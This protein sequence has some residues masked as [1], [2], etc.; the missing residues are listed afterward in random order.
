[1]N[2]APFVPPTAAALLVL[3]MTGAAQAQP[4]ADPAAAFGARE[5]VR[6]V[7]LSPDGG[8]LIYLAPN[9]GRSVSLYAVDLSTGDSRS[10]S[11]SSGEP[12][13]YDWCRFASNE[14]L[15]CGLYGI[16]RINS[17]LAGTVQLI[18]IGSDGS[19]PI[20]IIAP[21]V[22]GS[23]IDWMPGAEN[24]I[25]V[26]RPYWRG[27]GVS[28]ID[29]ETGDDEAVEGPRAIFGM[30]MTDGHG[31]I[32]VAGGVRGRGA[33]GMMGD[34]ASYF[35]R[36]EDEEKWNPLGSYNF[37]TRAG[38]YPL[39]VDRERNV[40]YGID[41]RE[42]RDALFR[43]SL[44]GDL[45]RELVFAHD[46]VDLDGVVRIGRS[47]RV[48]GATFADDRRRYEYFDEQY[49][50]LALSLSRALPD[51]P[52]IYFADAS[53]DENVLLIW[54]GSDSDPGRYYTYDR[55]TRALNEIMLA[56]PQLEQARL[57]SVRAISYSAV[58]GMMI[59]GYLTMPP[60]REEARGLPAIVM[61]HGGP[62]ARDEWGFDWLAQYFAYQGYAV[63]QPNFRGSAGYGEDWFVVNGFQGWQTAIGDVNAGGDW[64]VQ[65]GIADPNRLAI[66][67]WSYGGYAALQSAVLDDG[68][69]KAIVAI[70]PVTDL[71][72]L[73]DDARVFTDAANVREYIGQGAHVRAGSPARNAGRITA[74]VLLIHGGRDINV[75]VGH[76]ELMRDRLEAAGGDVELIAFP[77]L[78]H[79]L[80]DSAARARLL[81]SSDVFLQEAFG[82][83]APAARPAGPEDRRSDDP[84]DATGP[85]FPGL[86]S[87]ERAVGAED[88]EEQR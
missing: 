48:I 24:Q 62:A 75:G 59:P 3:S 60:G 73:R 35:Y 22:G 11:Y 23:V 42:G 85:V 15:V 49:R 29:V 32:R 80:D 50:E 61:P 68:L 51:L 1:M 74:P 72:R 31:V 84:A 13:A 78:D 58:D 4:L 10:I 2:F 69:F 39:A 45:T 70:A 36:R 34:T 21:G 37:M 77:E 14:R 65:Q 7:D 86:Q 25:L 12:L 16:R 55:R 26:S 28:L 87:P 8:S 52:L 38:F 66:V 57:A 20:A 19:D 54:A 41:Q 40:A 43:I 47:G 67:G 6:G 88:G 30:Y 64:L 82:M 46:S 71:D 5:S 27:V 18:G 44:D 63:L 83:P 81:H 56:R 79:Q 17:T 33:T 9:E 76:S 53:D